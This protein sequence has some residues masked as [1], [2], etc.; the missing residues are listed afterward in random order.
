MISKKWLYGAGGIALVLSLSACGSDSKP[1][2]TGEC[3]QGAITLSVLR[4]EN[5]GPTDEQM[6]TYKAANPCVSF[7]VDQVPFGQ[8]ASKISVL[9]PSANPPDVIGYDSPNTQ[10]YASQGLLLPLDKYLPAGWKDDVAKATLDENSWDGKVY[11]PGEEQDAL[12]LY[13]NKKLTDAAG[14]KPPTSLDKAWTWPQAQAAFLKCQQGSGNDIKVYGLAPSRL[15]NGTPGASY[16]DLLFLRSA[17]DPTAPE[18]STAYKTFWALS[19]D[20]KQVDGWLNTPEAVQAATFYQNM[21]QGPDQVTSKTGL[22]SAL[23]NNKACFDLEVSSNTAT[24]KKAGVDFGVSPMPY[25]KTPIVHTGAVTVGV[26]ARSKNADAAAAF[27]M[28]ISTGDE[29]GTWAE[30][31]IRIP[32]LKSQADKSVI[33]KKAPYNIAVEEIQQWGQPRPP[34]PQFTQYD[35]FVTDALRDIAYGKDPKASLDKAVSQIQPL[36]GQ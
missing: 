3:P 19:R 28:A 21:F 36:L 30:K 4:A 31:N 14:I 18:D 22:P 20:G 23:I 8:L 27:V 10:S 25:F 26:T 6:D 35:Q 5:N 24:L 1:A 12:A 17:G 15:G 11:S 33:L 13:Y 16:R 29:L 2:T 34:S 7:K 32:V 9:G